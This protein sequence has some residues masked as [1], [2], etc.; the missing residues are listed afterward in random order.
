MSPI[1]L[2][3]ALSSLSEDRQ[4]HN[5]VVELFETLFTRVERLEKITKHVRV[6][7]HTRCDQSRGIS[8]H[9]SCGADGAVI[10]LKGLKK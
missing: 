1:D 10:L 6:S 9:C 8:N 7:H 2:K 3:I 5:V 4:T